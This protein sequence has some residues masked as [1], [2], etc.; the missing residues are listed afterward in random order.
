MLYLRSRFVMAGLVPA[1]LAAMVMAPVIGL[2]ALWVV[3]WVGMAGLF[4]WQ[5]YRRYGVQIS[6]QGLAVRSG[7]I[8][9]RV[10]AHLFR[11]VQ[12]VTVVQSPLQ[13]RKGMA[14]LRFFL[15]SGSITVPYMNLERALKLRDFVLY[16]VESTG[17]IQSTGLAL[18]SNGCV[19][20]VIGRPLIIVK[21]P[22]KIDAGP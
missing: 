20:I 16:Q 9:Y 15:A 4:F 8:G 17:G 6:S 22:V 7:L 5:K 11:K 18:M 10:V 3:I 13:R 12:R 21:Q 1:M 2:K 19:R 14:T